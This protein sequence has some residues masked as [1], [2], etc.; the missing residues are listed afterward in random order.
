MISLFVDHFNKTILHVLS[1]ETCQWTVTL[2]QLKV[3]CEVV[4][5]GLRNLS[6]CHLQFGVLNHVLSKKLNVLPL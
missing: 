5:L 3:M 6:H 4:S 2:V 1:T